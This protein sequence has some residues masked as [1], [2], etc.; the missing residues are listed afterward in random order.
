LSPSSPLEMSPSGQ[1]GPP[2]NPNPFP[3]PT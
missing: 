3:N 2:T 1:R